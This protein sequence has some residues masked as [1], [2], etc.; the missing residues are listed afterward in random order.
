MA[1]DPSD[2]YAGIQELS[3][4]LRAW[5]EGRVVRTYE[6]GA[7][8]EL[9]KWIARNKPLASS[10]LAALVLAVGGLAAVSWV[11]AARRPRSSASR[12]SAGSRTWLR[13]EAL[14]P[15]TP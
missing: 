9:R 12:T 2:R 3:Q 13:A 6:R 15:A 11:Q 1:R 8:A 10:L 14:W 5:T 4:E 7:W